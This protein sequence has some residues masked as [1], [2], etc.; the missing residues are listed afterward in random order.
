MARELGSGNGTMADKYT[1]PSVK[2]VEMPEPMVRDALDEAIKA[3]QEMR[4]EV[5]IANKIKRF[6]DATHT[7]TWNCLVGSSFGSYVTHE[8]KSYL[9]FTIGHMSIL[10]WK[11]G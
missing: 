11:C 10:L 5:E 9:Y 7:P 8:S 4:T 3:F 1:K 2:I 6:M